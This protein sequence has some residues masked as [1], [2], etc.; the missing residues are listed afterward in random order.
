MNSQLYGNTYPIPEYLLNVINAKLMSSPNN[1][2]IKRAKN[3]IKNGTLS[4]QQ[5]KRIK[6]FYDHMDGE[7]DIL[8]FELMG[9]A[10]MKKFI[11]KTLQGERNRTSISKNITEPIHNK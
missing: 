3:L 1:K 5:M 11:E 8:Q 2:G 7:N 4:Y 6:N 10:I 9:G